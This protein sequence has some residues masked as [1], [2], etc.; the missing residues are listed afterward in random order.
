MTV[1]QM[2]PSDLKTVLGW[3]AAEGW[4]PGLEDAEAFFCADPAG[5]F[6]KEVA[7]QP[8]AA[9]SV[10]NH[11]AANAF[12]GLYICHPDFRGHGH[13]IEVWRAG[14]AHAG[15][16]S[17]G[18]DGV[19][20]QQDNYVSDGFVWH[21]RT[22]RYEGT[23]DHATNPDVTVASMADMPALLALDLRTTGHRRDRFLTSW[24][25][26]T[27]TRKTFVIR[28]A[29]SIAALATCRKCLNGNKVGPMMAYHQKDMQALLAAAAPQDG[30]PLYID[31][32]EQVTALH[33]HLLSRSFHPVFETARM[34]SGEPPAS[35]LLPFYAVATLELG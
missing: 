3:A 27:A 8:V 28:R 11:D 33:D 29:G 16:R 6:V 1:R 2:T 25:A 7:G 4:N 17:I 13:G 22:I 9:I 19:P 30:A 20:A 24:F 10:V 5:F 32:P 34:Y 26:P 12:L 18:L 14:K 15:A 21:G 23:L 31:V 35:D